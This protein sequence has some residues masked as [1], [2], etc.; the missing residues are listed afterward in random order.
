MVVLTPLLL[1]SILVA[2]SLGPSRIPYAASAAILLNR[3]GLRLDVPHT[4][5]Q[6]RII[7]Q[8]RLPRVVTAALVGVALALSGAVLQGL[9]RN[10]VAEPGLLGVSSG[11]AAAAVAAIA[12]NLQALHPFLLAAVAFGGSVVAIT[13][14]YATAAAGGRFS[15]AALLLAGLAVSSF[16]GAVTSTI[17]YLSA[18]DADV[19]REIFFWLLGGLNSRSWAH[20]RLAAPPIVIGSLVLLAFA[21]DL[22]LLLLGE[23]QAQSLGVP[24]AWARR[25]LLITT[26]LV[27]GVAVAVSGTIGFVG[28]IVP[29]VLRLV[30]GPDHRVLLPASALG[31]AIFL[32]LADTVARVALAPTEM[33]LGII[34]AFL[35]APFFLFLLVRAQRL[36]ALP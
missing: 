34:T 22:N 33:R 18:R 10:P 14:V 2:T 36:G 27:T 20:V 9:F 19:L 28:L 23:E 7:M 16:L 13:L 31:G 17:I 35:G 12:F 1:L 32:I 21:R 25:I 6:D 30:V 4:E 5:L 24:V 8:V 29:H 26:A 15:L 3:T 11:G